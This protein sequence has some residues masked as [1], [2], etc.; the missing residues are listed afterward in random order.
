MLE[1][2]AKFS[3]LLGL[4]ML[5]LTPPAGFPIDVVIPALIGAA[6]ACAMIPEGKASLRMAVVTAVVGIGTSFIFTKAAVRWF[7]IVEPDYVWA[8]A[9]AV[10]FLGMKICAF[11]LALVDSVTNDKTRFFGALMHW[12]Y[13]RQLP[14]AQ[15]PPAGRAVPPE[16]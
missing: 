9:G 2:F 3:T 15:P 8:L 11:L 5:A 16:Q 12:M 14:P 7:A 13:N 1:P 10:S 4:S 6:L